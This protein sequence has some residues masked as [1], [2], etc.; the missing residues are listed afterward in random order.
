MGKIRS[1]RARHPRRASIFYLEIVHYTTSEAATTRRR[2]RL[3][4]VCGSSRDRF[5]LQTLVEVIV[6]HLLTGLAPLNTANCWFWGCQS[7]A[8][9]TPC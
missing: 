7:A 6:L 3:R 2:R 5:A 4:G 1:R 9:P 8:A